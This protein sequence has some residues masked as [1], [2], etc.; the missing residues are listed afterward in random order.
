MESLLLLVIVLK[1]CSRFR[2]RQ[3][4]FRASPRSLK[5]LYFYFSKG[6]KV[7]NFAHKLFLL[8]LFAL[9]VSVCVSWVVVNMAPSMWAQLHVQHCVKRHHHGHRLASFPDGFPG[10][11]P[12]WSQYSSPSRLNES[13]HQGCDSIFG[14]CASVHR[15][16]SSEATPSRRWKREFVAAAPRGG[17]G[18]RTGSRLTL[19]LTKVSGSTDASTFVMENRA[20]WF[21]A[22]SRTRRMWW[23]VQTEVAEGQN[24]AN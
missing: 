24:E 16:V 7:P 12:L 20:A 18:S 15:S 13:L 11:L 2:K 10:L 9:C 6:I 4:Q 1:S 14:S 3:G 19:S 8:C 22:C 17:I 5:L 23:R 21:D